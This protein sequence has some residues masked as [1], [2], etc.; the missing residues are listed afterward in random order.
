MNKPQKIHL[1]DIGNT[2]ATYGIAVQ[3]KIVQTKSIS[4]NDFPKLFQKNNKSGLKTDNLIVIASVVP[5]K[6]EKLISELNSCGKFEVLEIGKDIPVPVHSLYKKSSKLGIDRKIDAF[7][8]IKS[9]K[10]PCLVFD[11]GTALTCDLINE[12]GTFLGGLIIP[13][14]ATSLQ[15]LLKN[16]ALLPKV[17]QLKPEKGKPYGRNTQDCIQHGVIQAYAAMADGLIAKLSKEFKKKPHVIITGGFSSFIGKIIR[18]KAQ[19]NPNHTLESMLKLYLHWR[20]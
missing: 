18:S 14:P 19:V 16:T 3:G 7:G 15:S 9:N 6:T 13:G 12:K 20:D 11:F 17:L 10:L 8:A 4:I 1:I 5:E 2:S